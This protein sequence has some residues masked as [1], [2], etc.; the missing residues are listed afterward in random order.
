MILLMSCRKNE[1][2]PSKAHTKRISLSLSLFLSHIKRIK[3]KIE[4]HVNHVNG[5]LER[6]T[7]SSSFQIDQV[8]VKKMREMDDPHHPSPDNDVMLTQ[9]N[10]CINAVLLIL[11]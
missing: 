2:N 5:K 10:K 4:N 8:I 9:T 1:Q 6:K 11:F 7:G 3:R